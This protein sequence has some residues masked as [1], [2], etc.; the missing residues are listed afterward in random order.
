L[1]HKLSF[2]VVRDQS[3]TAPLTYTAS[4]PEL[5]GKKIT[6][7]YTPATQADEDVI[8]SYLPV[9]H[10]DGTPIQP[11]ELPSSLPAYLI[12]VKPELRIDGEIVAA[13][14]PVTLG[15]VETFT[16][17]FASPWIP[18]DQI[19][20]TITAGA[21]HAV[22]LDL[23]RI[24]QEQG[25]TLKTRL[26]ATRA[27]LEA[28]DFTGLTKDELVGDLL[29]ATAMMYHA[30]LGQVKQVAA[31]AGKVAS[32]TWP[33]E[34]IFKT[35][36]TV[37]NFFGLPRS[38]SSS[39]LAMDADRIA[40]VNTALD[41]DQQKKINF[42]LQTGMASSALEHSV[43]ERLFST[44]ESPAEGVS[45]VKVLQ[46]ANEQGIPIY[47]V[48]KTNLSAVLPQLQLDAQ[49][50]TDIQNAV[51][52]GKV[53]TVSKNDINFHGWVGCGYIVTDPNTGAGAYMIGGMSGGWIKILQGFLHGL[54][55]I[56]T[57]IAGLLVFAYMAPLAGAVIIA[58][59]IIY[60]G[61]ALCEITSESRFVDLSVAGATTIFPEIYA[62]K[63]P[64]KWLFYAIG[65]TVTFS[66]DIFK[67]VCGG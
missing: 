60:I 17:N 10:P 63:W 26:E 14:S 52:A 40:S 27:K 16:M 38:I 59:S 31:R 28:Q 53:V 35:D 43:P 29:Y 36:F 13:G 22:A 3:D 34:T 67:N 2:T 41:G 21:Y 42:M 39:G 32:V 56:L 23:G 5:A 18:A 61:L 20:N 45:A 66:G 54:A 55:G 7:S 47:T 51:N 11:E 25:Q 8:S 50:K 4:L 48:T 58:L 64:I 62:V 57:G 37:D 46:L 12:K 33:S 49:V 15:G 24:S 6:L 9:P 65:A 44:A 30:E 19:V 1:R